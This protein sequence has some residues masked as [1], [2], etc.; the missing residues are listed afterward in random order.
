MPSDDIEEFLKRAAQ[1]RQSKPATAPPPAPARPEYTDARSER[2][3]RNRDDDAPVQAILVEDVRPEESVAAHMKGLSKK[4]A[5]SE[6]QSN[7][8]R[9]GGSVKPVDAP[10]SPKSLESVYAPQTLA[11]SIAPQTIVGDNAG[12]TV[13]DRMV[14]MLQ[15][16]EGMM[17][18]MLLHEILRRPEERW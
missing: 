2:V 13:A 8:R 9:A 17:Q 6:R 3:P 5:Q 18:A 12:F 7:R 1:R 4:R 14:T 16:P 10:P 15:K 11:P